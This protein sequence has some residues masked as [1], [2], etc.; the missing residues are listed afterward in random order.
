[1]VSRVVFERISVLGI[2]LMVLVFLIGL[3]NDLSGILTPSA[4]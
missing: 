2:A 4:R 3:Q 1:M